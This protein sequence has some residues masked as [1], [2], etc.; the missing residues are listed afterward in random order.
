MVDGLGHHLL[1][2]CPEVLHRAAPSA[3]DDEIRHPMIIRPA[4]GGG[5]FRPRTIPL[6][7]DGDN[8]HLCQWKSGPQ[9]PDHIP[10]SRPGRRSNQC[11]FFWV[12]G[13]GVFMTWVKIALV[14]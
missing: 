13:Q 5:H 12:S 6:D 7:T 14:Q 9:H 10:D 4:D 3:G 1:V 2:K 8:F 11:D